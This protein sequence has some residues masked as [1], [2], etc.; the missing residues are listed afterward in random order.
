MLVLKNNTQSL[1]KIGYLVTTDPRDPSAFV[2]LSN[3]ATRATGVVIE[4]SAYRKPCRIATLGE[5]A[6]VFV[7]GNVA[8]GDIIRTVKSNDRV[9]LGACTVAKAGDAPYLKVG[10]AL[11][12][13]RGLISVILDFQYAYSDDDN[14]TWNDVGNPP[15]RV[16]TDTTTELTTDYTIVCNKTTVMT[17]NLLAATGSGRIRQIANINIGTVTVTP[18]GADTINSETTQ[19][20][21]QDNCMDIK[22][23]AS[24]KWIII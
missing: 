13:G 18:S 12:S 21:Y 3:G 14:I 10:E 17:V 7:A 19:E 2:Y 15:T 20:V 22:D 5:T 9:S 16:V 8:K 4:V 1:S 24:N 23:Y 6:K 11:S